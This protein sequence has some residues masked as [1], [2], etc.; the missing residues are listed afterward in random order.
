M[1]QGLLESKRLT[2]E[3]LFDLCDK[4]CSGVINIEEI[5]K[6]LVELKPVI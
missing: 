4:D 5:K 2:P 3:K 6:M 1:L